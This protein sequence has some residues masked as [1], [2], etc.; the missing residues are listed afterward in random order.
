M[1]PAPLAP[2]TPED[3][4]RHVAAGVAWFDSRLPDWAEAIDLNRLDVS[5]S[6]LCPFGQNA[7]ALVPPLYFDMLRESTPSNEVC[8][9]PDFHDVLDALGLTDA[10]AFEHGFLA[11]PSARAFERQI[12]VECRARY[13]MLQLAW[14]EV[15]RER[16]NATD[17][18]YI[19]ELAGPALAAV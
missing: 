18:A 19:G 1:P 11:L 15:I 7:E 16:Q 6:R 17:D 13:E 9:P 10:W 5:N 3:A 12:D 14:I 4:R 8:V 2:F